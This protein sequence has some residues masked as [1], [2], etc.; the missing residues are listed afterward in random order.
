MNNFR[1]LIK[2]QRTHSSI[3]NKSE[4]NFRKAA[5]SVLTNDPSCIAC[6]PPP[7]EISQSFLNFFEWAQKVLGALLYTSKSIEAFQTATSAETTGVQEIYYKQT[8]RTLRYKQV[9]IVTFERAV[10]YCIQARTE[11]ESFQQKY[12]GDLLNYLNISLLTISR[13][14]SPSRMTKNPQTTRRNSTASESAKENLSSQ[15]NYPPDETIQANVTPSGKDPDKRTLSFDNSAF[16]SYGGTGKPSK[17]TYTKSSDEEDGASDQK[18]VRSSHSARPEANRPQDSRKNKKLKGQ[19]NSKSRSRHSSSYYDSSSPS[20]SSSSSEGS[21][22]ENDEEDPF[23]TNNAQDNDQRNF[24]Q[25]MKG[26]QTVFKSVGFG[27]SREAR[28]VDLPTFKG[29]DQDPSDWLERYNHACEA[30]G[31]SDKRRLTLVPSFMKGSA[32]TWFNKTKFEK[33]LRYWNNDS[34]RQHKHRSF[35]YHFLKHYC[36]THRRTQWRSALRRCKQRPGQSVEEYAAEVESLYLK[37]DPNYNTPEDE[38][39]EQFLQGLR[40]EFHTALAAAAPRDLEEAVDRARSIEAVLSRDTTLSGYSLSKAYLNQSEEPND[41]KQ[42]AHMQQLIDEN[43]KK[44][45]KEFKHLLSNTTTAPKSTNERTSNNW[46]ER[47]NNNTSG[48]NGRNCFNCGKIGHLSRDCRAPKTNRNNND[49]CHAC[50]QIGHFA[51]NCTT[52]P[53]TP[54]PNCKQRGHWGYLCPSKNR[55]GTNEGQRAAL[56]YHTPMMPSNQSMY[57]PPM[58]TLPPQPTYMTS[59]PVY[60][61]H[62]H[63][64]Y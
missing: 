7:K 63:L 26:L 61:P 22:S 62:P 19:K 25:M 8:L 27:G 16:S 13:N 38:K 33:D 53:K 58:G 24:F 10:G 48:T 21:D 44:L 54:C 56:S 12:Q 64:N 59:T 45:I 42:P 57:P 32:L 18:N 23:D 5:D 14:S 50:K 46:R 20:S 40:P 1:E 29:G 4:R 55:F 34:D 37:L 6:N 9:P 51:K 2:Y 36:T 41:E 39:I 49:K 17:L 60:P 31:I 28:F 15:E 43:N 52:Q 30:N 11:T 3:H 35:V 47:P